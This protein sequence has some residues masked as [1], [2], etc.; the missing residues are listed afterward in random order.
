MEIK[1]AYDFNITEKTV[2]YEVILNIRWYICFLLLFAASAVWAI[3]I[4]NT[5][6]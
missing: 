4:N 5:G 2:G 6:T 3:E 1:V